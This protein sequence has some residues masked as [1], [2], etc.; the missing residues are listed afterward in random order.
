MTLTLRAARTKARCS[1]TAL[2]ARIGLHPAS[3]ARMEKGQTIPHRRNRVRLERELSD[4]LGKAI[5]LH[6]PRQPKVAR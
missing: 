1:K 6:F 5:T 4:L 2:A 3:I